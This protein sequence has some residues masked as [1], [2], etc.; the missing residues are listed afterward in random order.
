MYRVRFPVGPSEFDLKTV[1]PIV[2]N[3]FK[4]KYAV[5]SLMGFY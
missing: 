4:S 1:L 2:I 3:T 5:P